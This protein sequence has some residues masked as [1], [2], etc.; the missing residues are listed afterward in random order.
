VLLVLSVTVLVISGSQSRI[1]KRQAEDA[2]SGPPP[3]LPAE[4]PPGFGGPPFGVGGPPPAGTP[5]AAGGPPPGFGGP[6]PGVGG[7]PPGIGGSADIDCPKPTTID[8]LDLER[9]HDRKFFN[10]I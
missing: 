3:G 10:L 4:A 6:P 5:F 9:V 7:P 2:P 1:L 8:A